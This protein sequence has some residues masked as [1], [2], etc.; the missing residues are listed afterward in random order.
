M[1]KKSS[2]QQAKE[3]LN[4]DDSCYVLITCTDPCNSGKMEVEMSYQ[5]DASLAA[6]LLQGAQQMIDEEEELSVVL[7]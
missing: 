1:D 3:V 5:G 6:Y 7:D 4:N 2:H